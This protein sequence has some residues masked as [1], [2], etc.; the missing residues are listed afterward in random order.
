MEQNDATL[1]VGATTP[2]LSKSLLY[3]ETNNP[4]SGIAYKVSNGGGDQTNAPGRTV[5]YWNSSLMSAM[6]QLNF[7]NSNV[8]AYGIGLNTIMI[9]AN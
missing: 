4:K 1:S 8:G 6:T 7:D 2:G 3:S 5:T 9:S